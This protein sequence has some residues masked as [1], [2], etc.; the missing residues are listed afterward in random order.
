M[1]ILNDNKRHRW[2]DFFSNILHFIVSALYKCSL[3]GGWQRIP[4]PI[5]DWINLTSWQKKQPLNLP[6]QIAK[7]F[8][9]VYYGGNWTAV[10]V[11]GTLISV[12][13]EQATTKVGSFN[14]IAALVFHM[15][16]YVAALVKVMKSEP[17]GAHDKYSF[18][19]PP[20][21]SEKDWDDLDPTTVKFEAYARK[22]RQVSR[23]EGGCCSA[24]IS[25]PR[26]RRA[27]NQ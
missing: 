17:L 26:R 25:R 24:W 4:L 9:D 23:Q 3:F 21:L 13:W 20:I 7:L 14:T 27:E 8:K 12:T 19:H 18:D 2:D 5:F 11:Q 22:D 10:N 15:N 1:Q 16:Y 6:A